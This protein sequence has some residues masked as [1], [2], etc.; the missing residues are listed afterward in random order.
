[1]NNFLKSRH[2]GISDTDRDLMLDKLGLKDL[3]SLIGETIPSNI[4]LDKAIGLPEPLAENQ[5][6]EHI[7]ALGNKNKL[8]TSYIGQGWYD[9]V[10]PSVILRN[11]FENPSWYT[12]YTP[13]QAEISQGR[14]E[15]LLN[16]QTAVSDFTGM[17]LANASL[18]DEAT[19]A[20]EAITMAYGLRSRDKVKAGA[21]LA[22]NDENI[23]PQT[24][25]VIRTRAYSQGIELEVGDF[26][27]TQ[28]TDKHFVALVQYPNA[29]GNIEDYSDFTSQ[30]HGVGA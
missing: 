10:A 30:A 9:T 2:I 15:A 6:L 21:K 7:T 22:F 24:L 19:A 1:M 12:S 4:L 29:N 14:L 3:D 5:Y 13:Y 11:V 18:L 8:F 20:A 28:L 27:T 26:A 23:F 17:P 16:F 25:A